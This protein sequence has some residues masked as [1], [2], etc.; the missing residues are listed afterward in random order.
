M[1]ASFWAA[2][3]FAGLLGALPDGVAPGEADGVGLGE[4]D[5]IGLGE[6]LA[7]D[8]GTVGDGTAVVGAAE[9]LVPEAVV[10]R[11]T[12]ALMTS[13]ITTAMTTAAAPMIHQ[14]RLVSAIK[15]S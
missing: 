15:A 9:G 2:A 5:G 12:E 8:G 3:S 6:V 10:A 4:A 1:A 13:P 11:G 7:D 14:W